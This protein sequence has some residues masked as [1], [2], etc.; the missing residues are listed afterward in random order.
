MNSQYSRRR[1][2]IMPA[3]NEALN[4]P[5]VLPAIR[6]VAADYDLLVIDDGSKDNTADVARSL[7]ATVISLPVNLGYGGAV[8]TG[9]RFAV[10][11]D[12]DLAV[13]MDADG[14]HDPAGITDLA[15]A[16]GLGKADIA[17]GS[18]FRGGLEYQVPWIKRTGMTMFAWIASRI[19]G[20]T[21]TDPTSGFQALNAAVLR[22]VAFDNY[23]VDFPD[24]DTLLTLHFA[25]FRITEVPVTMRPR[26]SGTSMHSGWKPFYYVAKM[27][28]SIAIVLLRQQGNPKHKGSEAP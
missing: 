6:A 16:V 7:G 17:I 14:Q 25:G 4:L 21:L 1:L 26:I 11:N 18:R 12:Y 23:P 20:Q 3:H 9:F 22:Y 27:S 28:L 10:Y 19:I 8:Q 15:Q 24:V 2:I 13:V 5:L